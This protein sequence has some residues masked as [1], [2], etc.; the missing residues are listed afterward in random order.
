[1]IPPG[2]KIH[3]VRELP[4]DSYVHRFGV[5]ASA[6]PDYALPV[7]SEF[8]A[9]LRLV[10]MLAAGPYGARRAEERAILASLPDDFWPTWAP[11]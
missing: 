3:E 7:D 9:E 8:V 2:F 1:M 4:M 5:R 6:A 11:V 10:D